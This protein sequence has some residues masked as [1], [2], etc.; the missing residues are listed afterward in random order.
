MKG[1]AMKLPPIR[2]PQ[3]RL[4]R[5]LNAV[6]LILLGITLNGCSGQ[7]PQAGLKL[8]PDTLNVARTALAGGNPKLALNI[9][10]AVLKANPNNL[11]A[12]LARGDAF[13]LLGD[14]TSALADYHATLRQQ[15]RNADAELGLGRCALPHD[16][17][18]ASVKFEHAIHDA[19]NNAVAFNDLGIAEAVQSQFRRAANSFRKVLALDSSMRAAKINLG[20]SLALGGHPDRAELILGPLAR[21]ANSTPKIRADYATALALAGNI[22]GAE[23]ELHHDMPDA[24]ARSMVAQ[25]MRL[26]VLPTGPSPIPVK[27]N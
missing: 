26:K 7:Q 3:P 10:N 12:R 24:E 18:L 20:M 5:G 22:N 17:R 13:Y 15:P 6:G 1:V 16:P 11:H 9:A 25:L 8:G 21:S 4:C 23:N 19:P 2:K 27:S 14:C